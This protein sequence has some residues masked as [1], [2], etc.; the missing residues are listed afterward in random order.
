MSRIMT[1]ATQLKNAFK[2]WA[3]CL[4]LLAIFHSQGWAQIGPPPIITVQPLDT[5]V[6]YGGTATFTVAASSGTTL[7]Y[8]W[9]KDGLVILGQLLTN[10]TASTLI[11]TNVGNPD[12]GQYYVNVRNAGGT[13]P[14]RKASLTLVTNGPPVAN[15]DTYSTLENVP[16][17]VP[18][19]A[20]ILT[21]DTDFNGLALTAL[22][23]TNVSHGVLNLNTNGGF[24]YT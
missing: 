23:V 10:Q 8:Q 13:V 4:L 15:N 22:L 21:N 5:N 19:T 20:G 2:K 3:V 6:P 12:V 11:L 9:Y 24:T 1:S 17:I 7:S 18:A 16:L 14:S